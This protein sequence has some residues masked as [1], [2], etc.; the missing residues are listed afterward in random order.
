ML[1]GL[2]LCVCV[3]FSLTFFQNALS[4]GIERRL[5][6]SG[7]IFE[8]NEAAGL[9]A[10]ERNGSFHNDRKFGKASFLAT[11]DSMVEIHLKHG[12]DTQYTA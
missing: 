11:V 2:F 7:G 3:F 8:V 12:D 9:Y 6:Q 1:T 4:F 5:E 10:L